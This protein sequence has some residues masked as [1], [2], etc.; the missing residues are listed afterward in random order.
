[1]VGSDCDWAVERVAT[2][3]TFRHSGLIE[4]GDSAVTDNQGQKPELARHRENAADNHKSKNPKGIAVSS[5]PRSFFMNQFRSR[6]TI[7]ASINSSRDHSRSATF[8][9]IAGAT[10]LPHNAR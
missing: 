4:Y 10:E 7:A 6:H 9:A 2:T 1:M 5:T 3:R 8:A